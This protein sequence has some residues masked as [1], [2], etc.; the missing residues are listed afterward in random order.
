[1]KLKWNLHIFE[2]PAESPVMTPVVVYVNI[3]LLEVRF[4]DVGHVE[5]RHIDVRHIWHIDIPHSQPEM[6]ATS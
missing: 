3:G 5:V 1:M 6:K 4:V 2:G